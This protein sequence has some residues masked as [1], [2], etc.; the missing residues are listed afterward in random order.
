MQ[1]DEGTEARRRLVV[2]GILITV[3]VYIEIVLFS[4]IIVGRTPASSEPCF[5][6]KL[7]IEISLNS[8]SCL[9][10]SRSIFSNYCWVK[11]FRAV[12]FV[13]KF[14]E[15]S[16]AIFTRKLQLLFS[17]PAS[18]HTLCHLFFWSKLTNIQS[19]PRL[20]HSRSL[21]WVAQ[22]A[23][24]AFIGRWLVGC[25]IYWHPRKLHHESY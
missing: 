6:S 20:M 14:S 1:T 21:S 19:F 2:R 3:V 24:A 4:K 11:A 13:V 25:T 7:A 18:S 10:C 22:F 12:I 5:G 17:V 15:L 9:T 16:S 8:N 23:W